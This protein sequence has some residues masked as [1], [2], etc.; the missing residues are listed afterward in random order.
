[1]PTLEVQ[2]LD[3]DSW[4]IVLE[5]ALPQLVDD[6]PSLP[7]DP[8]RDYPAQRLRQWFEDFRPADEWRT[9]LH[10]R[11][12]SQSDEPVIVRQVSAHVLSRS[13]PFTGTEVDYPAAGTGAATAM[14]LQLD[15]P[16]PLARVLD[17]GADGP[18]SG[19]PGAVRGH[20]FSGGRFAEF[21]QHDA[22]H[23]YVE[24]RADTQTV[25]WELEIET[26]SAGKKHVL[27]AGRPF[28]RPFRTTPQCPPDADVL[29]LNYAWHLDPPCLIRLDD[30]EANRLPPGV[31]QR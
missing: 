18:D 6:A 27:R 13:R 1:M 28:N 25:E 30:L 8:D 5:R 12:S 23:L 9:C 3:S 2:T 14:A 21:S 22:V 11:L 20:F 15:D 29:R 19:A 24:A 16:Q 17:F 31:T 26:E 10:V 7:Y 4:T